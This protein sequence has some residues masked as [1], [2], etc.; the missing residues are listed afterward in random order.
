MLVDDGSIDQLELTIYKR[1]FDHLKSDAVELSGIIHINTPP[2]LCLDRIR[3]RGREGEDVIPL[4]YLE[5][6]SRFQKCWLDTT[7][8]PVLHTD[9]NTIEEIEAF[10]DSLVKNEV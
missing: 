8:V 5:N 2:S 4:T 1:L 6:L 10:L 7:N 3:N 9:G